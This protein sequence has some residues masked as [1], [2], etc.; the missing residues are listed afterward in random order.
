MSSQILGVTP[1][2][3]SLVSSHRIPTRHL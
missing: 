1:G 2:A 3:V